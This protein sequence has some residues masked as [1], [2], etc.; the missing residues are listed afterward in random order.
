MKA[1]SIEPA[2]NSVESGVFNTVLTTRSC[3]RCLACSA[4]YF[5]NT[6]PMS[7]AYTVPFGPTGSANRECKQARACTDVC[8]GIA[9]PDANGAGD[10]PAFGVD[11]AGLVLKAFDKLLNVCVRVGKLLVHFGWVTEWPLCL[12]RILGHRCCEHHGQAKAQP[13]HHPGNSVHWIV[14]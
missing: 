1:T 3:P 9:W 4:I 12:G 7:T 2:G 13:G 14:Q 5:T 10:F 8:Y 11:V 6:G